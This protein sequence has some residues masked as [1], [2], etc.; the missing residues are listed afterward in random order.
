MKN[1]LCL[2]VIIQVGEPALH[3]WFKFYDTHPIP[4]MVFLS[5]DSFSSHNSFAL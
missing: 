2:A 4:T 1:C 3:L 5:A